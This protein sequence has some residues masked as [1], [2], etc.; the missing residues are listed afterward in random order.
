MKFE[1]KNR[2]SGKV[3][4]NYEIECDENEYYG[5]KLGLAVKIAVSLGSNLSDADL[6]GADLRRADLC[7][8]NLRRADLS[9]ADLRRADLRR[10]DLRGADLWSTVGNKKELHS[11]QLEK[12]DVC[13]G[14]GVMQIGCQRHDI[15][16]WRKFSDGVI[17]KM[18]IGAMEWWSKWKDFI[19]MAIEK[20]EANK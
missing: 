9:G 14:F 10:A 15:E 11:M 3:V 20:C 12:Y 6:R 7:G 8:A 19:F 17:S 16:R 1:I 18:D 2:F 4:F 13:F 5:L